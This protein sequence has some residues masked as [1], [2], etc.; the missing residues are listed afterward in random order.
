MVGINLSVAWTKDEYLNEETAPVD[1]FGLQEYTSRT[2]TAGL[3]LAPTEQVGAAVS[4]SFEDYDGVQ[5]SRNASPGQELDVTRNWS[6]D[7]GNRA[8]SVIASLDALRAVE[9]TELRLSYNY[10]DYKGSYL[11]QLPPNTTLPPP[12]L[13]PDVLS[14]ETRAVID[15]RYFIT[16]R[17]AVGLVY[18]YDDY[19]VSDFAFSP[20]VVSGVAQPPVEEGQTG[21]VNAL[22]LNY[23]YRPYTAHTAWLRLTYS[24]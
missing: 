3:E 14:T 18:W 16:A 8:W 12:V 15:L 23:F 20:D 13:L 10:T 7:E 5:Q 2:Y 4:L 22:L 1:Q 6:V 24:W 17:M 11:H 21:T 19:D 9:D